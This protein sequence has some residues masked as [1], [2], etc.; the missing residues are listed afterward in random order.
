MMQGSTLTVCHAAGR[1]PTS[2]RKRV[3]SKS[4]VPSIHQGQE[5]R[6]QF[7]LFIQFA[8]SKQFF[9][10]TAFHTHTMATQHPSFPSRTP[11][12]STGLSKL[13]DRSNQ[14]FGASTSQ[15][16]R[17]QA[18]LER[19]RERQEEERRA[20]EELASLSEEQREEIR[21]AVSLSISCTEPA[22]PK[23]VLILFH[24]NA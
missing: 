6:S 4:R 8:H 22:T 11:Y 7:T 18:R 14:P 10:H 2:N 5:V 17:E 9:P 15:Q 1:S 16:A 3:G 24:L 19:E 13:P 21:E 12:T 23:T 20:Q